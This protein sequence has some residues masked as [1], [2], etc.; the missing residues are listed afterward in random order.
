MWWWQFPHDPTPYD[1]NWEDQPRQGGFQQWILGVGLPMLLVGYGI[2]GIFM[3]QIEFGGRITMTFHGT[4]ATAFGIAWVCAGVFVHCHYF[5]G[6]VYNQ[7][8]L[9][10]LGKIAGAIGFIAA[11]GF[12][13]VRNG[14]YG[15]T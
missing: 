11:L 5:W 6:N 8:W 10:V 7:A 1:D 12:V 9:A 14:V 15:I 3:R 13:L 4:N 2:R